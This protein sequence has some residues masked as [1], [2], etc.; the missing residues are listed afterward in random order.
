VAFEVVVDPNGELGHGLQKD[1][2]LSL[3]ITYY[4]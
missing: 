3:Y 4:T 2:C 1:C